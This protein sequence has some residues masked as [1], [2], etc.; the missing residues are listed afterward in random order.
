M[1]SEVLAIRL[2]ME[3]RHVGGNIVCPVSFDAYLHLYCFSRGDIGAIHIRGFT[4]WALARSRFVLW[5]YMSP[6]LGTVL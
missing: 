6:H 4:C 3:G 1:S 5:W 2:A